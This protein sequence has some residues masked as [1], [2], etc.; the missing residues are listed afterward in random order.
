MKKIIIGI[1]GGIGSGKSIVSR[2]VRCNGYNV[3]DCDSRAKKIMTENIKVK[4]SL[5]EVLGKL[6]F[7]NDGTIN[8]SLVSQMLFD[9]PVLR[10][11]VNKIVHESVKEDF[12]LSLKGKDSLFFIES[13]LLKSSG[14]EELC[15]YIWLIE[16]PE[17]LRVSRVISRSKLKEEEIRKR[18]DSQI[19]E[20]SEFTKCKTINFLNDGVNP[21]LPEIIKNINNLKNRH[22]A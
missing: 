13:A 21:I 11:K 3:Y 1:T 22:H 4:A 5:I 19:Y 15:D 9:S 10:N 8:S 16:A 6:A 7:L 20:F 2:I 12:K 17:N 14:L 18:M